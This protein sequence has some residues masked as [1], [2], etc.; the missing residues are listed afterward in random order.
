MAKNTKI[1]VK[2]T[3]MTIEVDLSK[4]F[5]PSGSGKTMIIASTEGSMKL[6]GENEGVSVGLNVYTKDMTE[7]KEGKG[8]G[9]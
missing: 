8:K 4:R 3:T 5:G 9:K 1:T 7:P 6:D 2:G